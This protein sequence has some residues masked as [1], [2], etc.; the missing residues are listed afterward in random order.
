ME[1]TNEKKPA[2]D[3]T[4]IERP[5]RSGAA[6]TGTEARRGL[7]PSVFGLG[8]DITEDA[9]TGVIGLV[10]DA[11]RETRTAVSATI[12]FADSIAK[13]VVGLGRRTVERVDRLATDV[14]GG[15]ERLAVNTFTG[16]RS[17]TDSASALADQATRSV[18]GG[19]DDRA[20]A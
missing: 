15:S 17:I 12:D 18:V 13:S 2:K 19:R 3:N 6:A 1:T 20:S 8:I 10:D 7:I 4:M 5:S 16:L 9:V 11:R 14:L